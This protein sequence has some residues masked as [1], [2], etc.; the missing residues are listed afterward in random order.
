MEFDFL[1]DLAGWRRYISSVAKKQTLEHDL[2]KKNSLFQSNGQTRGF[3]LIELLVVIAILG[4]LSA[5]LLPVLSK[6]K[7]R[8]SQV[9]DLNNLK[10]QTIA[11]NLYCTDHDDIIPWP[12]W[13]N[14][15]T[16]RQGWLYKLDL[17]VAGPAAYKVETG[18]FW[19]VLRNPKLYVCPMDN[20]TAVNSDGQSRP[21]QISSYAMNGAVI[22]YPNVPV[23][24][25]ITPVKLQRM[26][27]DDCAFWETDERYPGY[28]NDGANYPAEGVSTRHF[29]GAI[30]GTFGGA[31][32]YI[33][34]K[35]WNGYVDDP[36]RNRL[37]CN[38]NS[39]NGG[40]V[41]TGHDHL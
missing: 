8:A 12:N 25:T 36:N 20:P 26:Q 15:D 14:G 5:L 7:N 22:G 29:E 31:V 32:S 40:N 30:Q 19:P 11:L 4:I 23:D 37:W 27:A 16:D 24:Y 13:D 28:F 18:L 3:T 21:Q 2:M 39:P 41:E 33:K 35:D 6:A 17:T 34:L 10:E 1:S 38:P 9:S